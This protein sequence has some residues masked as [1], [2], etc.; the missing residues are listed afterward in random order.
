MTVAAVFDSAG[1]LLKTYRSVVKV[2]EHKLADASVETTTL[3]FHDPDRILVLLTLHSRDIMAK[4]PVALPSIYLTADG[5]RIAVRCG[6]RA[7]ALDG[8]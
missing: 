6:A 2:D 8:V 4:N 7:I 3:T 5:V 1:T